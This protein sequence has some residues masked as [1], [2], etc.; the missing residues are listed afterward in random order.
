MIS[1]SFQVFH[2]EFLIFHKQKKK[3]K[4]KGKQNIWLHPM[5]V[6][7]GIKVRICSYHCNLPHIT[8]FVLLRK[9]GKK[10]TNLGTWGEEMRS[11]GSPKWCVSH[12]CPVT[13]AKR[14]E[15]EALYMVYPGCSDDL[16]A[17]FVEEGLWK[18]NQ[19]KAYPA[20]YK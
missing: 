12:G 13:L 18:K 3:K 10:Q 1:L 4:K 9:E 2:N 8:I 7:F 19:Y 17:P 14:T 20:G 15:S 11:P 6:M 5:M 16:M